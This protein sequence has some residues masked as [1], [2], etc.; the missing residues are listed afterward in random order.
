MNELIEKVGKW[1]IDRNLHTASPQGQT[2]KVIEEFTKTLIAFNDDNKEEV[3]DGIGDTYV[4]LII[5]CKQLGI[6]FSEAVVNRCLWD[7]ERAIQPAEALNWLVSGVAKK[8]IESAHLGITGLLMALDG[9]IKLYKLTP[10]HCI[11]HRIQRNRRPQRTNDHGV[12]VKESDLI[13]SSFSQIEELAR[14]YALTL[15]E[16]GEG[17]DELFSLLKK[18][19]DEVGVNVTIYNL[20]LTTAE[21]SVGDDETLLESVRLTGKWGC[22]ISVKGESK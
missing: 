12:F 8:D 3:I 5:L 19:A 13:S 21:D 11:S 20:H 4:A 9:L 2:L 16:N 6:R 22:A 7:D 1:A 14:Q 10:E 18:Y 17:D 15:S